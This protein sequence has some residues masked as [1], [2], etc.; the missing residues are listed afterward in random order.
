MQTNMPP[1]RRHRP[2]RRRCVSSKL[3]LTLKKLR[4]LPLLE[5]RRQLQLANPK[6]VRDLST[7][8]RKARYANISPALRKKLKRHRKALRTFANPRV[9]VS[10][11]KRVLTQRGGI[12]PLLVPAIVAAIGAAG[13]IG[14]AATHAAISKA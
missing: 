9:S 12:F 7:A 13:S 4:T 6:F 1:R 14:A 8:T 3:V 5:Q 10:R 11:K 2:R